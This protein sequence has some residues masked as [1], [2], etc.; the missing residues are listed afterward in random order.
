MKALQQHKLL[1]EWQKT[2]LST[3]F[4]VT[5]SEDFFLEVKLQIKEVVGILKVNF[6]V[7][8]PKSAL[9]KL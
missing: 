8:P 2:S 3:I 4:S 5:G 7:Y 9:F 1:F 6:T